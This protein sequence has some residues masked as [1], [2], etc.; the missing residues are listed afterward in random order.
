MAFTPE[1]TISP[2]RFSPATF[3]ETVS[4]PSPKQQQTH[5]IGALQM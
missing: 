3:P 4:V 1:G 5:H 2:K